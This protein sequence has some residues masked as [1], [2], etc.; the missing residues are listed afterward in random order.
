M[1]SVLIPNDYLHFVDKLNGFG[2][3]TKFFIGGHDISFE[4]KFVWEDGSLFNFT[5]WNIGK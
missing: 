4:G 1:L 5:N 2:N 3:G